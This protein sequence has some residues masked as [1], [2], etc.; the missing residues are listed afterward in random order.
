MLEYTEEM[1]TQDLEALK[2]IVSAFNDLVALI[3]RSG[4]VPQVT[5]EYD[6]Q[7]RPQISISTEE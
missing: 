4:K 6:N 7:R 3:S 1:A 2:E 5:L